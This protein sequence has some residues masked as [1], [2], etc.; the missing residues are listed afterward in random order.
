MTDT[1]MA[2]QLVQGV[3]V[4]HEA[5]FHVVCEHLEISDQR[6]SYEQIKKRLLPS[7]FRHQRK[8]I[9]ST[10]KPTSNEHANTAQAGSRSKKTCRHFKAGNCTR[11]DQ[12]NFRHVTCQFCNKRGHEEKNCFQKQK[13]TEDNSASA[14]LATVS[15]EESPRSESALTA[16]PHVFAF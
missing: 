16:S 9:A 8:T 10:T 11:G 14:H 15:N 3:Q 1:V 5:T 4:H 6:F 12:C 7:W 13:S 2:E